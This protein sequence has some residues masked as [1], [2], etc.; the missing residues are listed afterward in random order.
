MEIISN[1]PARQKFL[2]VLTL[3]AGLVILFC[4]LTN[5]LSEDTV[6]SFIFFY[7]MGVPFSLLCFPTI[8]DLN[9]KKVYLTWLAIGTIL[10]FISIATKNN[11]KFIVYRSPQ[12]DSTNAFNSSMSDHST[13]ALKSLFI[14]LVAYWILNEL[15]KKITRNFL[16]NTFWQKTW[17]NQDASRE[18]TGTDVISNIILYLIIFGSAL[19]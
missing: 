17:K 7:S 9:N 6:N 11:S 16:V 12:F 8:I 18:I 2:L 5:I 1:L 13:S 10:L 19:F 14:F 15:S 4:S 3:A